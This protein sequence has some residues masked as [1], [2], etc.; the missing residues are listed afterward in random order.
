[1]WYRAGVILL[2]V[3]SVVLIVGSLFGTWQCATLTGPG[4]VAGSINGVVTPAFAP[5]I[6]RPSICA[7]ESAGLPLWAYGLLGLALAIA[8]WMRTKRGVLAA[9]VI[10]GS[11][12][13]LAVAVLT[14]WDSFARHQWV[15]V[16]AVVAVVVASAGSVRW[17]RRET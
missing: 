14:H 10:V 7:L 4:G 2:A 16:V 15:F 8:L 11:V 17:A 9:V 13:A 5:A 3:L 12:S 1:M 6:L